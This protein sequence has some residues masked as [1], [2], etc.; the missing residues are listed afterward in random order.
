[1]TRPGLQSWHQRGW[2]GLACLA[3]WTHHLLDQLISMP[4]SPLPLS[5]LFAL[6]PRHHSRPSPPDPSCFRAVSSVGPVYI[7]KRKFPSPG[8]QNISSVVWLVSPDPAPAQSES[9]VM[10]TCHGGSHFS[11]SLTLSRQCHDGIRRSHVP[12]LPRGLT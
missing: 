1:M 4:P 2:H 11:L 6:T 10:K 7:Q 9:G 12:D 5:Q 3:C 8:L